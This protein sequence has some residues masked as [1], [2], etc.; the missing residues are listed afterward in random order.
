MSLLFY[1]VMVVHW[2]KSAL[3][4]GLVLEALASSTSLNASPDLYWKPWLSVQ[5][6][7]H[8]RM[9]YINRA[10]GKKKAVVDDTII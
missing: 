3:R 7:T 1:V 10:T 5:V 6:Q 9:Q 4:F 2:T 8:M